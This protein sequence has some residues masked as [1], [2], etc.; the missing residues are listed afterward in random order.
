M[1]QEQSPQEGEPYA[2]VVVKV[3]EEHF[4]DEDDI[5]LQAARYVCSRLEHRLLRAGHQIKDWLRG[6]CE[7]DWGVYYESVFRDQRF[8]YLIVFFPDE[9]GPEQGLIAVQ[10]HHKGQTS[11]LKSLFGKPPPFRAAPS[12]QYLMEELGREFEAHRMLTKAQFDREYL[13]A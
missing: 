9:R 6:G 10:F 5:C 11:F 12:L 8:Q 1:R 2:A 13:G 4:S 3:P 7:E